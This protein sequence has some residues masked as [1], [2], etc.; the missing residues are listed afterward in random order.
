MPTNKIIEEVWS[1]KGNFFIISS[2]ILPNKQIPTK[3]AIHL[4]TLEP[5]GELKRRAKNMLNQDTNIDVIWKKP[6]PKYT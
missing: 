4:G 3:K 5:L 2:M 6:L 1:S